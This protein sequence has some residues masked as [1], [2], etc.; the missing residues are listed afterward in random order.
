MPTAKEDFVDLLEERRKDWDILWVSRSMKIL[1]PH[2]CPTELVYTRKQA[3]E[4]V[5]VNPRVV[6]AIQKLADARNV[7]ASAVVAEA[8]DILQEMASKSHLPTVRWMGLL[9]TK[10]IKRI[11]MSIRIN[12]SLLFRIKDQMC[13]SQVQY[14]YAPT[15]RSYLDFILLSYILFSYDMALPNIASGMDFYKMK[16]VGELLRQTGAF[17]MRRSFALDPLYKEI[18]RAYVSSLVEHSDRALEFF[19]E[20]TRSRSQKTL[21]PKFG[22]LATVLESLLRS[23][24]PDIQFIPIS[25]SYDKP[26]EELLF[27]YELLGV[28]KPAESTTGLFR[29]LSI[30]REPFAHGHVYVKIAPPISARDYVD[31]SI[32]QASAL[33]LHSKLPVHIAKKCAYDI[34]D[35][36]KKNTVLTP[37]NLIALLFNENIHS[38]ERK[39]YTLDKLFDDYRWIKSIFIGTFNAIVHPAASNIISTTDKEDVKQEILESLKT[40]RNLIEIDSLQN[41]RLR[42]RHIGVS[43]IKSVKGHLLSEETLKIAVPSINLMIYVNPVF[44]YLSKLCIAALCTNTSSDDVAL[45]RYSMLRLLLSA[46]FALPT[47]VSEIELI[48][49]FQETTELLNNSYINDS[50][51]S[52]FDNNNK[53]HSILTNLL[54]PYI[55]SLFVMCNTLLQWPSSIECVEKNII[56]ECQRGIEASFYQP[57][58]FIKNPYSLSLDTCGSILSSLILVGNVNRDQNKL[59]KPNR[60]SLEELI[61]DLYDIMKRHSNGSYFDISSSFVLADIPNLQAKL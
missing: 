7:P 29:S 16:I 59:C 8:Q 48:K 37:F 10:V 43:Q 28:P 60:M 51:E 12:E 61:V 41:L 20:G 54:I 34:I 53:L 36:H 17:Y 3:I 47:D 45:K 18:F 1:P 23:E 58:G 4:A 21:P 35:C 40:H 2:Q 27:V 49:E 42:K 31:M 15:H 5:L 33:T 11:L 39:S 25:I 32:R 44:A 9:I 30:L 24:V 38:Q 56:T 55:G 50:N 19:I 22:L 14:I 13:L 57:L 46:E 26:L 6:Y 52:Q